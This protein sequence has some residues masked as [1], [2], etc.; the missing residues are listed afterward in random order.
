V[1]SLAVLSLGVLGDDR[2]LRTE[3]LRIQTLL[4]VAEDEAVLQGREFGLEL[5]RNSSRFVEYDPFLNQW[6]ALIGDDTLRLRQLPEG[7]EFEFFLEGRRV[8]LEFDAAGFEGNGAAAN[9]EITET[10]A[11]HVL[12][13]SSGDVMPFE[14]HIVREYDQ[15]LIIL[16]RD[17]SGVYEITSDEN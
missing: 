2:E 1:S 10:H 14:L 5:M 15:E 7:V 6:H 9:R 17:L 8:L 16:S 12:I 11:P 3:A 4:E 13:F